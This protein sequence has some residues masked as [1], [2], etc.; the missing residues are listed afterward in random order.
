MAPN[1]PDCR[2][3]PL[4]GHYRYDSDATLEPSPPRLLH[5]HLQLSFVAGHIEEV[6]VSAPLWPYLKHD[7][8]I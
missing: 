6:L 7:V 1:N 5:L 8:F 3:P 4:S 2:P